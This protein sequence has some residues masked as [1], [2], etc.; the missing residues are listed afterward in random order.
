M[1]EATNES[2]FRTTF[3]DWWTTVFGMRCEKVSLRPEK[4][5][6]SITAC[7][8]VRRKTGLCLGMNDCVPA[9]NEGPASPIQG[10]GRIYGGIAYT[11]SEIWH[12][13]E[14]FY[15]FGAFGLSLKVEKNESRGT[16][17]KCVEKVSAT[18]RWRKSKLQMKDILLTDCWS[19]YWR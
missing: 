12:S 15:C 9:L 18:K 16:L 3:G 17:T 19:N 5:A 1:P 13:W 11:Q 14:N 10:Q 6:N 8:H 2:P 4:H 7:R